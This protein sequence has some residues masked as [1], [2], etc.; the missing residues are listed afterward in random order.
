MATPDGW[1][2]NPTPYPGDA[3]PEVADTFTAW[4]ALTPRPTGHLARAARLA[5]ERQRANG[6]D[7]DLP[8][9]VRVED[10][11]GRTEPLVS[12]PVRA[13]QRPRFSVPA[14]RGDT[15]GPRK[16]LPSAAEAYAVTYGGLSATLAADRLEAWIPHLLA[17]EARSARAEVDAYR[18]YATAATGQL[19]GLFMWLA[20]VAEPV[21]PYVDHP[22]VPTVLVH[23]GRG[24]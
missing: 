16:V 20:E 23:L 9:V 17:G 11:R 6:V 4:Q 14:H 1:T 3:A 5:Q 24:A 2:D 15:S 7:L 10:H 13:D 8:E 12:R 18:T 19:P 21:P 22:T